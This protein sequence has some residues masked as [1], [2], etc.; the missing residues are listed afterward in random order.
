VRTD[1]GDVSGTVTLLVRDFTLP[2][3]PAAES[4]FGVWRRAGAAAKERLLLDFGLQPDRYDLA[5][6][7]D[8]VSRGLGVAPLGFW[9]GA[10]IR[11]CTTGPPRTTTPDCIWSTTR[12]TRSR[13]ARA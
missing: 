11:T 9:S 6:E 4:L 13:A 7:P 1:Q 8:L 2:L 10:D 5:R 3:T 12:R